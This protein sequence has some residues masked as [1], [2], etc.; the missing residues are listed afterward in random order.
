MIARASIYPEDVVVIRTTDPMF[1]LIDKRKVRES[2]NLFLREAAYDTVS[3]RNVLPLQKIKET[4]MEI[5]I[6]R[7]VRIP[8]KDGEG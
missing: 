7:T 6:R 1:V 8:K 3:N 2:S 5:R 4:E